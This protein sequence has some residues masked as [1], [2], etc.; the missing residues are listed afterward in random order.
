[1]LITGKLHSVHRHRSFKDTSFASTFVH[2]RKNGRWK[3]GWS[4]SRFAK[5]MERGE[6]RKESMQKSS[7]QW[8]VSSR[9]DTY[10]TLDVNVTEK[11]REETGST[12]RVRKEDAERKICPKEEQR[13]ISKAKCARARVVVDKTMEHRYS[14]TPLY[15]R[16]S[17][18]VSPLQT[19]LPLTLRFFLGSVYI[20]GSR[21]IF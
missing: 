11:G 5:R 21:V 18:R 15:P 1:M 14:Q 6:R 13:E 9:E 4:K 7:I 2:E 20:R 17:L 19:V 10:V 12:R 16:Y 8:P 3:N